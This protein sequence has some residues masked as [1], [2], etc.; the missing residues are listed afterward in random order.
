[1]INNGVTKTEK[2]LLALCQN[3]FMKA[4]CYANPYKSEAKEMCDVLAVFDNHVF[5]FFDRGNSALDNQDNDID[6]K[7]RR[8]KKNTIEKQVKTASGAERYIS[9][10]GK[11]YFDDKCKQEIPIKLSLDNIHIHKIIVAHGAKNHCKTDSENNLYGSLALSYSSTTCNEN[12]VYS[13]IPDIPFMVR[14]DKNNLTHVFDEENLI[15]ILDELDTFEDFKMYIL[16]K[17]NAIRKLDCLTYCGEEDLLAHYLLNFDSVSQKH[18]IG[19]RTGKE[20]ALH[21]GEGAWHEFC[22]SKAYKE[23]NKANKISYLWDKLIQKTCEHALRGETSGNGDILK[24]ES[25]VFEM[26]KESRL[27]R[28][29]LSSHMQR[30]IESFPSFENG[31]ARYMSFMTSL[32]NPDTGYVFLQLSYPK[33]IDYNEYREKR[34][35]ILEIACG[36]ARNKFIN[37]TKIIGI[38]VEPPKFYNTVS[39]DFLLLHCDKWSDEQQIAYQQQNELFKFFESELSKSKQTSFQEF[40]HNQKIGRNHSCPC[41]SG[42]KYKK[43]CLLKS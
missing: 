15:M 40:P 13:D 30:G 11:I 33:N 42:K 14:M 22:Q 35:I 20:N 26:T 18:I 34:R 25:A 29:A 3:V 6:V 41:G 28:R 37:L 23:R 17:E 19:S 1:M 31:F 32:T 36:A 27:S 5:I 10:G 43:C 2:L 8:W 38:A 4:W 16:E 39:E 12:S 24:S 9:S 21:I 7:W